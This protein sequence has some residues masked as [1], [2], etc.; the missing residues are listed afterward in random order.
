MAADPKQELH[1]LIDQLDQTDA[2]ETLI[3]LQGRLP[4]HRP[5]ESGAQTHDVP[6]RH[7]AP[8]IV[9]IDNLRVPLFAPE[10]SADE[11]EAT[12][13]RWRETPEGD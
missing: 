5:F 7:R 2:R 9:T 10:E 12:M 8:A 11:F 1:A 13:R 4:E 6:T 3:Y